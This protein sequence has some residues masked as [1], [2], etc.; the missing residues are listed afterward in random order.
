MAPSDQLNC[1]SAVIIGFSAGGMTFNDKVMTAENIVAIE[2]KI[3]AFRL[4]KI[5]R[6]ANSA[7]GKN[8]LAP[9]E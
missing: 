5:K 9:K 3:V 6:K 1:R 8:H 7:L 2:T 4:S